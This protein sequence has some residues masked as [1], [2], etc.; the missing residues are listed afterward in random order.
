MWCRAALREGTVADRENCKPFANG[1]HATGPHR[2]GLDE[3]TA[4]MTPDELVRM[5]Q[6]IRQVHEQ[7]N[8]AELSK[9]EKFEEFN[10]KTMDMVVKE[11]RNLAVK[12]MLP[13]NKDGDE[14]GCRLENDEVIISDPHYACYPN[15][16][17][18]V[19]GRVVTIPVY[20]EDGFQYRPE[21]IREK[22]ARFAIGLAMT[23]PG[24]GPPGG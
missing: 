24:A 6:I 18:F 9:N 4:G 3:P 2:I 17:K 13:T 1:G 15:F 19:Q 20:E 23:G 16:I 12:E 7:F 5:I 8:V 14:Q 11:A 22:V 10:K 21:A